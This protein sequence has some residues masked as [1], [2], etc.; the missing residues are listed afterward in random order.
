MASIGSDIQINTQAA[1]KRA[2]TNPS[3]RN[4]ERQTETPRG[5]ASSSSA[6]SSR[7]SWSRARMLQ[8]D[9]RPNQGARPWD[10]ERAGG[11]RTDR[12][13]SNSHL[14]SGKFSRKHT[15][16]RIKNAWVRRKKSTRESRGRF[17]GAG[18]GFS[19]GEGP[20]PRERWMG[21]K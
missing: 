1:D 6:A 16:L 5:S 20:P 9:T 11:D 17:R 8:G 15:H 7:A 10:Q 14:N 12:N 21:H 3:L 13:G 19:G 2:R 18:G 4:S